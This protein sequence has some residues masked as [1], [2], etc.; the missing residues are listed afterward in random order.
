M[1]FHCGRQEQKGTAYPCRKKLLGLFF[2]QMEKP[3]LKEG[4]GFSRAAKSHSH[5]GL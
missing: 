5:S 1:I 2:L 4:H 3:L